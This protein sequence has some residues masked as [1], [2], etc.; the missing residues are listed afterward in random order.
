M[1]N[2]NKEYNTSFKELK[3]RLYTAPILYYYDPK[4]E[5]MLETNALDRIVTIVLLQLYLD[6]KQYPI[7]YFLKTIAPIELNY[8]IYNKEILTIVYALRQQHVELLGTSTTIKVLIDYYSLEYFISL[9]ILNLQQ[10]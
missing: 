5:C 2:F 3:D 8:L 10:A 9:K 1:F 6:S 7:S 4:L